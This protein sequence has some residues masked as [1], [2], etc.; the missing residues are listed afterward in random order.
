MQYVEVE[1]DWDLPPAERKKAQLS[2][3][4][5]PQ[6]QSTKQ[7]AKG[8]A[9]TPG[10]VREKFVDDFDLDEEE[11]WESVSPGDAGAVVALPPPTN[12]KVKS[13]EF[14]KS[15]V[16]LEQ[17]PKPSY[18]EFAVIG[19]SNVGKS[20][21]INM[22][23]GRKSLAMVSKTPGKTVCINHF[24]I[25][26]SWYLVDLPGYGYAKRSKEKIM[27]WNKF[28]RQYFTERETLAN[29][30][31]LVDASVPP[32]DVDL[33]SAAWLG[34]SEVPFTLVFTKVDKRKKR[35]PPPSE[36]I[37]EFQRLLLADWDGLPPV[38]VTSSAT[39]YGKPELLQ[40]ISQMRQFFNK[41]HH[42]RL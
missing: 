24:L 36:N 25:N 14:V 26:R 19:R 3:G 17:C 40:H 6:Q 34:D 9:T 28:T 20:S 27:E 23:T 5:R 18:P 8:P 35:A 38:L 33:Q 41:A 13:A 31:L 15:S 7:A 42:N 32:Q 30:M 21:L 12:V 29:V 39:G 10:V 37:K 16:T 22:L 1:D 4:T 2:E 11:D